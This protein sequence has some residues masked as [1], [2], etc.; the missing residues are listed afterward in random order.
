[1]TH[2][3]LVWVLSETK[4]SRM[5]Q[6]KICGRQPLKK[7]KGYERLSST[8]VTSSILEYIVSF[9]CVRFKWEPGLQIETTFLVFLRD[10]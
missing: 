3:Q 5:D 7:L 10:I 9:V 8:I 2:H 6:V 1:M 4:Y